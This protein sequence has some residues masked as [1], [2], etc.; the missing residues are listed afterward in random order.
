MLKAG[1]DADVIHIHLI[2]SGSAL[3]VRAGRGLG[4]DLIPASPSSGEG[5]GMQSVLSIVTCE[6]ERM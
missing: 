4:D 6:C 5:V 2:V 3:M 1:M